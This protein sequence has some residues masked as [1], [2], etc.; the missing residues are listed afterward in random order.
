MK[1]GT[2]GG[3]RLR[4]R[5]RAGGRKRGREEGRKE[6]RKEGKKEG[7]VLEGRE[8]RKK[9]RGGKFVVWPCLDRARV[10]SSSASI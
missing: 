3:R 2:K 9:R 8:G 6:G 7:R 5:G 1:K 4:E 10:A